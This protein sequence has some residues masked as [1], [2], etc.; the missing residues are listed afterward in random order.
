MLYIIREVSEGGL[1]IIVNHSKAI[2]CVVKDKKDYI[3]INTML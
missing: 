1:N 3:S 2:Q